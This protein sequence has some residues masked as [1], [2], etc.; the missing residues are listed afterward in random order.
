MGTNNVL[1]DEITIVK[2]DG[3]RVPVDYEKINK[4]LIWAT[5]GINGVSAS[6]IAMNANLQLFS[7]IKTEDIH[8]V[9]IQSAA[10]LIKEDTPNYQHVAANLLNYL[11]RKQIFNSAGDNL[12]SLFSVVKKNVKGGIYDKLILEKY[13][14][15]E[16]EKLNSYLRHQRD[17]NF[18]YAGLQQMID[19]YLLKDRKTNTL[20]ETPQFAYMLIAMTLFADETENRLSKVRS[21]Y[22]DIS[23]FKISLPTPIVAGVRT[24]NRQ[25]SSCVLI[26]IDDNLQSIGSS[27]MAAMMYSS[28]R[29]G[30]GLNFGK[31]R[32]LNDKIRNGEVVH[33]GVIPFMKMFES[34]VKS[35][36]QNGIRGGAATLYFPFWH[37]EIADV[38]VLKNNKGTDDNRVR[39]V[40]YAIQY[41][42]LFYKRFIEDKEITLFST[43]DVPELYD[44]FAKGNNDDFEQH[45]ETLEKNK[46][47]AGKKIRARELMELF[48]KE[49]VET[50]RIYL[51]NID[52][53]NN[54][55]SFIDPI[56]MSNLCTEVTLPV[57]PLQ[58]IDD[59]DAEI[60]LCVLA[61]IN[62]G[63]IR[64]L[65]EL[66]GICENIVRGL[67]S[68]IE[69]Q[70]Y[71]VAAAKKM[72]KRRSLG[73]GITNL[74][75]YLAKNDVNYDDP[76]A[77][78]LVDELME[79]VQY[80]L[81][82]ASNK[83]AQELG[84]CEYFDKTKYSLGVLPID[85][86]CKEVDSIVKRKLSLDWEK[87]RSN[88]K[89]YGLRHSTM[90]AQMPCESSSVITNATNGIEP[91]RSL[92]VA[93]TSKQGVNRQV[94]PDIS[95]L[96]NKY[97][98]AFDLDG[99]KGMTNIAA[100]IQKWM[101]QAISTNHYYN[102]KKYEG[103]QLPMSVVIKDI[104]YAYKMGLKTLYYANTDDGSTDNVDANMAGCE[105]GA[106]SV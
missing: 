82:K 41:N 56:T 37:K 20:Y 8:K 88:I 10:N 9:M 87:L 28:K 95:K 100:V 63:E 7:G 5:E 26:E 71:T 40:D 101:D 15:E 17:F 105:S 47:I 11:I 52:H 19:K 48:A 23:T 14:E 49:R 53:A 43:G 57:K 75:Y 99:N 70:D 35:V 21:F 91:I 69:K 38:I 96:K 61:A 59:L 18:V 90:T 98:F 24:P 76:K 30:L 80:Y 6:E 25:W 16:F 32:A 68:V 79:H 81:L 31:I 58:H 54:H 4:V 72:L 106:C 51:M 97:Q 73:V 60:A 103:N 1:T 102:Y 29:A 84:P 94:A 66:E 45:Y 50:G 104:M 12:P 67:D 83:M 64:N 65:A 42:R 74:A 2:R 55:S 92:I 62:C 33:T 86:Y 13:S 39:K 89:Q 36:Q 77:L 27:N 22:N 3:T 93:K 78:P 44:L 34:T 85:T 46:K